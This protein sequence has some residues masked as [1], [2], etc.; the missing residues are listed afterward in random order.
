MRLN[1]LFA[2]LLILSVCGAADDVIVSRSF[3]DSSP[4]AGGTVIVTL[5][6]TSESNVT[7]LGIREFVPAGWGITLLSP[8]ADPPIIYAN[9]T[10]GSLN[11]IFLDEDAVSMN[12]TYLLDIPGN[13]SGDY[14]INGTTEDQPSNEEH[15]ITGSNLLS[16]ARM[17]H[18][19]V[20]TRSFSDSTPGV[21]D[22]V[23]VT[24]EV[25]AESNVTDMEIREYVPAGWEINLISPASSPPLI[26]A[27][28][29]EGTLVYIFSGESV[30]DMT[31]TYSL[32][33]PLNASGYYQINGTTLDEPSGETHNIT[34]SNNLSVA[35]VWNGT[36]G[37]VIVRRSFSDSSPGAG[38]TVTVSLQLTANPNV[39]DMGIIEYVPIG[40]GINMIS[41]VSNGLTIYCD[42]TTG[43]IV[44][45]LMDN[46][47]RN[48]TYSLEI[49]LNATLGDY[50]IN[51]TSEDNPSGEMRNITGATTLSV[52]EFVG[53]ELSGDYWPCDDVTLNEV[54]S[55]INLWIR[56]EATLA[57]VVRLI[58]AWI[59]S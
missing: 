14:Q 38:S 46:L 19:V 40:W 12:I 33:I 59:N 50:Q 53:C 43:G 54:V 18:D 30:E 51:G 36:E 7:I 10:E 32:K 44:Y 20:V 37:D 35:E 49:P 25:A 4:A 41:P 21:G 27:N 29:T 55:Y 5:E 24:L 3:S 58:V 11:Y 28:E 45:I 16:V 1:F 34:G 42:E 48:I 6:V 8:A 39:T 23:N 31:I 57:Q 26:A 17:I 22:T 9:E 2:A 13:A 47:N 56:H 15:N 52:T